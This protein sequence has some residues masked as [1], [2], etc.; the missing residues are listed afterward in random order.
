MT[1]NEALKAVDHSVIEMSFPATKAS[2]QTFKSRERVF[3]L[4]AFLKGKL[5]KSEEIEIHSQQERHLAM[6]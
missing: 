5:V 6:V 4:V 2:S 1:V 3:V